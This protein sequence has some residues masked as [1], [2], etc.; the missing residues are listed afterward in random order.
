MFQPENNSNK[1]Q[2]SRTSEPIIQTAIINFHN[3]TIAV[4]NC[5]DNLNEHFGIFKLKIRGEIPIRKELHVHLNVDKS[6]S[7]SERCSDGSTKMHH[8]QH[9]L[10]NILRIFHKKTE[11]NISIHIKS[12]DSDIYTTVDTVENIR[13]KTAEELDEI[14]AQIHNIAA[15]G[16][17]NIEKTL[18]SAATQLKQVLKEN[19]EKHIAHILLTDGQITDGKKNKTYLKSLINN[20]YPNIFLGY[21][22]DHDN[23]LL[24]SLA[25]TGKHNEYRFIDN[26]EKAGLVYG[27]VIHQLLYTALEDVTLKA[28]NCEIYDFET[29]TWTDT[30]YIGHLVSEQE[31]MYQIR[32]TNIK[33]AQIAVYGRTIHKTRPT[34]VLTDDVILQTHAVPVI[35]QTIPC[36]LTNYM[37]RQKTQELLF[38]T[39]EMHTRESNKEDI[40]Q[41]INDND[42]FTK[43]KLVLENRQE[44]IE[45]ETLEKEKLKKKM[46]D[47]FKTMLD[48]VDANQMKDNAFYKM[49]CDDMYIAIKSFEIKNGMMFASARHTSQ[50]RQQSYTPRFADEESIADLD[51]DLDLKQPKLKRGYTLDPSLN[52]NQNQK[53]KQNRSKSKDNNNL[54]RYTLSQDDTS[55]YSSIGQVKMMRDVSL[56]TNT[57][58]TNTNK[59]KDTIFSLETP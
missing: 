15:D 17:T 45:K 18:I 59:T 47:F 11:A 28:E 1:N 54:S 31:K 33:D 30:L 27:E 21:G 24:D 4:P 37:F 40:N 12:F 36:D 8:I 41:D 35:I 25:S 29:N 22:L 16:S 2:S 19:L 14:V 23:I 46:Q 48:Y 43:Y 55:P 42:P 39:K 13:N 32:T 53:Q 3:R 57:T 6:G 49:L 26:L 56:N 50:G 9:T 51:L 7:M 10:E 38:L 44:T 34:E 58:N 20:D 52:K 5:L